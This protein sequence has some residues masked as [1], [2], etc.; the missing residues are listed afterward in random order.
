MT[1]VAMEQ[2]RYYRFAEFLL[3]VREHALI[4]D[5]QPQYLT[6]RTFETYEKYLLA[7]QVW[8]QRQAGPIRRSIELLEEVVATEPDFAAGW[9]ALASACITLSAYAADSMKRSNCSSEP[10]T[11][12]S[13]R[14]SYGWETSTCP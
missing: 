1:V 13:R 9:A 3:D 10:G 8:R 11:W 12:A 7:R 6:P 2:P 4:R 14:C 5:G